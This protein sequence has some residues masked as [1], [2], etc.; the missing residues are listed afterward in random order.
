MS[1][2]ETKTPWLDYAPGRAWDEA[3]DVEGEV[4][5]SRDDLQPHAGALAST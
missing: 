1:G 5:M 2:P 4:P 3:M